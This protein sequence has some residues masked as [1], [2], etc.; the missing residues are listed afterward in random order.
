MVEAEPE[1]LHR[2]IEGPLDPQAAVADGRLK[3]LV[4]TQH[5]L[6]HL[7]AMFAPGD[8]EAVEAA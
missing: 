2:V 6:A 4:G 8:S 1:A 3:L 7:V 5:E